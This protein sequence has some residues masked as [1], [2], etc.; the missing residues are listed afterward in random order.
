VMFD[1][2]SQSVPRLVPPQS[3][4]AWFLRDLIPDQ[5]WDDFD[6]GAVDFEELRLVRERLHRSGGRDAW[7]RFVEKARRE[8][9]Q[10]LAV[11]IAD[12]LAQAREVCP[13]SSQPRVE[14]GV[15]L[16]VY[17]A[18]RLVERVIPLTIRARISLTSD[19][20]STDFREYDLARTEISVW[21]A[22]KPLLGP[23]RS[24]FFVPLPH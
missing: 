7:L 19:L 13:Q 1:R 6:I 24:E 3:R 8:L 17:V 15:N 16:S 12:V 10:L 9:P 14:Y 2:R 18:G 21:H 20:N 11:P 22:N 23:V 4:I 5:T